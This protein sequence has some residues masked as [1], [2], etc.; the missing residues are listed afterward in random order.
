M[1]SGSY[2][3]TI[4]SVT[5]KKESTSSVDVQIRSKDGILWLLRF[6]DEDKNIGMSLLNFIGKKITTTKVSETSGSF[7]IE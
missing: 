5:F 1:E 3:G 7:T 6:S 2:V 4:V